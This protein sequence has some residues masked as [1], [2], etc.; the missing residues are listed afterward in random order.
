M[1]SDGIGH[2][3]YSRREV[4]AY[5]RIIPPAAADL[6]EASFFPGVWCTPVLGSGSWYECTPMYENVF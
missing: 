2:L 4:T 6:N 5:T 1:V 3:V